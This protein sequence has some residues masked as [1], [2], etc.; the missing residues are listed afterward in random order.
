VTQSEI[1]KLTPGQQLSA[2]RKRADRSLAD[3]AKATHILLC[4]LEAIERDD[5]GA[6]GSAPT[7]VIGYVKTY[8]KHV[9]VPDAPLVK[10][11]E[12]YFQQ[13]KLAKINDSAVVSE[14]TRINWILWLATA[15][16]ITIFIGL[17][18]WFFFK[19]QEQRG[20]DLSLVKQNQL[21][22][23]A[24]SVN[25]AMARNEKTPLIQRDANFIHRD[26]SSKALNSS[27]LTND[28]PEVEGEGL[29]I[30]RE[31]ASEEKLFPNER[32]TESLERVADMKTDGLASGQES[33]A[34]N[35]TSQGIIAG[36]ANSDAF[37]DDTLQL[38]FDGDCWLEIFDSQGKRLV[39]RLASAGENLAFSGQAPFD[40]TLGDAKSVSGQVNGR[41]IDLAPKLGS[42]VLRIQVGP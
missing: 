41:E 35:Q 3:I 11:L 20:A 9:G 23:S 29:A 6:A 19:Q 24:A 5:Y 16:A 2:A 37:V 27:E 25:S 42:R 1:I 26:L 21:G 7:F 28:Q 31:Q 10:V 34:S 4:H 36:Q 14:P 33:N 8:A 38:R 39:S 12:S 18:Q 40:I 30:S 22:D 17:G 15:I 13:R 32:D